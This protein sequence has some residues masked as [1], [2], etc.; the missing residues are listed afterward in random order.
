MNKRNQAKRSKV[1]DCQKAV[2]KKLPRRKIS[3]KARAAAEAQMKMLT[4]LAEKTK[5]HYY[6]VQN[7]CGEALLRFD[8]APVY[9]RGEVWTVDKRMRFILSVGYHS[10]IPHIIVNKNAAGIFEL[11]DGKQRI[12][13]LLMFTRGEL[14][15]FI[16]GVGSVNFQDL[17][18]KGGGHNPENTVAQ[19]FLLSFLENNL[20]FVEYHHL[21]LEEQAYIFEIANQS[22]PLT[23]IEQTFCFNYHVGNFIEYMLGDILAHTRLGDYLPKAITTNSRHLG[24]F[25]LYRI[26]ILNYG[27]ISR[28]DCFAERILTPSEI[29]STAAYDHKV[30]QAKVNEV[31]DVVAYQSLTIKHYYEKTNCVEIAD[32]IKIAARFFHLVVEQIEDPTAVPFTDICT[33]DLLTSILDGYRRLVFTETFVIK[34]SKILAKCWVDYAAALRNSVVCD[35]AGIVA[36]QPYQRADYIANRFVMLREILREAGLDLGPKTSRISEKERENLRRKVNAGAVIDPVN[37]ILLTESNA[38]IAHE[39]AKCLHSEPGIFQVLSRATNRAQ[40][41]GSVI[42]SSD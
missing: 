25:F 2:Y 23:D 37:G 35:E 7:I 15:V 33:I 1:P 32:D 19:A 29:K 30:I 12:D 17:Q 38:D 27:S 41:T 42:K 5:E 10:P 26:I 21:T 6:T 13:T 22:S 4:A 40:G 11:I 28:Q 18:E 16:P 8:T 20:R 36:G 9:Q 34:H 3:A 31:S 24:S 14:V 39:H